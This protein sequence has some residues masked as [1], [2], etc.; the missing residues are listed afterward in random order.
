MVTTGSPP[1]DP[2]PDWRRPPPTRRQQLTDVW[3]GAALIVAAQVSFELVRSVG[4]GMEEGLAPDR[5]EQ[6]LWAFVLTVPLCVRRRFPFV[7][8]ILVAAAFIGL[9]TR[10]ILESFVTSIALFLAVFTAGAWGFDR[11]LATAL[12]ALVVFAMF[13]WLAISLSNTAWGELLAEGERTGLL[14]PLTATL[15]YATATNVAYFAG[16]WVFGDVSWRAARTRCELEAR[17][18][19]LVAE[20]EE[21]ARRAVLDER[22]RIARELHDVVAHHVSVMGVQAGAARHVLAKD[23]AAAAA[24]LG[25]IEG[26]SRTAVAEMR[27]LLGVLRSGRGGAPDAEDGERTA[28]SGVGDLGALVGALEHPGLVATFAEVGEP[29]PLP[30]AMS[31][32]VYRIAQEALTNVVKHSRARSVDVRLRWLSDEVELEVVDDGRGTGTGEGSGLGLMGMRERAHLQGGILDAGPRPV[33]GF[34]VRARFPAPAT[35]P[36][37]TQKV[38]A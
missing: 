10:F 1:E 16:A 21:K 12:R 13:T 15:V 17:N 35:D 22:V 30:T 9:Q 2:G 5:W 3:V 25:V 27:K 28:A 37:V 14:P 18:A 36:A 23:P 34:R 20:R 29:R 4:W 32:S 11:R 38:P 8:L 19:E 33:G 7:V 26:S 24:A 6:V 31:V